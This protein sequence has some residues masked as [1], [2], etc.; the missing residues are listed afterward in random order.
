MADNDLP[1]AVA[2]AGQIDCAT[3]TAQLTGSSDQADVSFVWSGPGGF[4]STLQSPLVNAAGLYTLTVTGANG[5]SATDEVLVE[6]P[7]PLTVELDAQCPTC[8]GAQGGIVSAVTGGSGN[9]SYLWSNGATTADLGA[10]ANG[11]YSVVVNDAAGCS[12]SAVAVLACADALQIQLTGT[13]VNCQAP[14]SGSASVQLSGGQAPYTVLWSTGAVGATVEGL[15]EGEYTVTVFDANQC[16]ASGTVIIGKEDC[17]DECPPIIIDPIFTEL[18]VECGADVSP[19]ALTYPVLRK[20]EKCP[21]VVLFTW[22]DNWSGTCPRILTRVWTFSDTEGNTEQLTQVITVV[23]TQGPTI[24]NVPADVTVECGEVP[25]K[26]DGVW[27]EDAC[28]SDLVV[29]VTDA[30]EEGKDK[31][32]YTIVR[33]YWAM[34]DCGNLGTAT[35]HITV[36]DNT[37]PEL[38]CELEAEVKATCKEI[39]EPAK[40]T[41]WDN[42]QGELGVDV[43]DEWITTK[44]GKCYIHRTYTAMDACGNAAT[45][46]QTIWLMGDCCGYA[47]QQKVMEVSVVPNPSRDI[48]TLSFKAVSEGR[49]VLSL[50][51]VQGRPM[52]VLFDGMVTEGQ[53]VRVR[54]EVSALDPGVYPYQLLLNGRMVHGRLMVQ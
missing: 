21:E 6:L 16:E 48:T 26:D 19:G 49:A 14:C 22:T 13:P 41:A 34:D 36:T 38:T 7:Q 53:E 15:C 20:D 11:T 50:Y 43:V 54:Q 10:V 33:T 42:C 28:K 17:G 40:C 9:Y 27:A 30:V 51:D 25:Q 1:Q 12:G 39:P 32:S 37:A 3:G 24:L 4:A 46:E 35:Q 31:C 45:A 2:T 23:D 8:G 52:R 47:D 5:C 44:E 29:H 18:T